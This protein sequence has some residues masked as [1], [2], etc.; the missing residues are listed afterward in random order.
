MKCNQVGHGERNKQV[1]SKSI[2]QYKRRRQCDGFE[3]IGG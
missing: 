3:E 1:K 2:V